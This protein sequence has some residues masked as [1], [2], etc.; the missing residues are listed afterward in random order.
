V[1][2]STNLEPLFI[3]EEAVMART[4]A[5]RRATSRDRGEW[6][7]LLDAWGAAR[8]PYRESPTG[9]RVSTGSPNGGLRSSSS[10]YE[11]ARGLRPPGMRPDG[12]FEVT[13][14]RTV[15]APVERVFDAFVNS[16]RRSK[17]LDD[18]RLTLLTSQPPWSARFDWDDGPTRVNVELQDKGPS[19]A[20]VAVAHRRLATASEAAKA[21]ARWKARLTI[22]KS[23]LES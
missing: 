16:R 8:R 19:K 17:W 7:A 12:T 2:I 21:K 18:G 14:S 23:L 20:T 10:K 5:L 1:S 4:D 22:L 15:A 6:F 9:S 13:A 11:Q 3:L